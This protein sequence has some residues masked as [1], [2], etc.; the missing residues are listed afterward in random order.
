MKSLQIRLKD[1]SEQQKIGFGIIE[2]DYILSWILF[3]IATHHTLSKVLVFKGGTALKKCYF[4]DYRFSQDLDFTLIDNIEYEKL[5]Q[6]VQEACYIAKDHLN[7]IGEKCDIVCTE[8][9]SGNPHPHGQKAYVILA[10][11]L[12][13][14]SPF[15]KVMVEITRDEL[16]I[17]PAEIRNII[18]PYGEK[19]DAAVQVY[20][21]EEI[22][23]EKL[24]A[25]LQQIVKL[26]ER[27]WGRSRARDFYDIWMIYNKY[28]DSLDNE[29][30]RAN[31]QKKFAIKQV[32]FKSI[33]DFFDNKYIDEL[34]R[35]WEQWLKAHVSEL[36]SSEIVLTDVKNKIL[37]AIFINT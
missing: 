6:Y 22:I 35:T 3:G 31:I 9:Q 23:M 34:T 18:H 21:L 7:N 11:L 36:P 17:N 15:I 29:L 30:I 25:I 33:N 16:V 24:R 13:H 1:F 2:Q 4:G 27:G 8:Y 32:E 10:Q 12:W 28:H 19:L 14:R 5:N 37:P 26:H 20:C